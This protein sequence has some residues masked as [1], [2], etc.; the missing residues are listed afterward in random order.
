MVTRVSPYGT[1]FHSVSIKARASRGTHRNTVLLDRWPE[2]RSRQAGAP[3]QSC[4]N[5]PRARTKR[6]PKSVLCRSSTARMG[7]SRTALRTGCLSGTG[8][9]LAFRI[10]RALPVDVLLPRDG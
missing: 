4:R 1:L 2:R 9:A 3:S 6:T 7:R 10:A 5:V 8:L